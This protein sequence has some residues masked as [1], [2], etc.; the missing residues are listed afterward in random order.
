MQMPQIRLE[1]TFARVAM[2]TTKPIQEIQQPSADLSIEQP[3]ADLQ[4]ETTPGKLTIDQS[5]ARA[6]VDLKS[7]ARRKEEF[8]QQG[9]QDW[10][11]GM[12][13]VSQ[14]GDQLMRIEDGGNPLIDQAK[15][16]SENPMYDFNIGWIPSHGSVKINYTPANV[17]I[18]V[19]RNK[20]NI[21]VQVNK[22]I[23]S[24]Q[25]GKVNFELSQRNTL[26]INF[27][28]LKYVGINYEQ[29]I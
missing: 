13:R 28:N 6:D 18:D 16:N 2:T 1:S 8:A 15:V 5:Q 25:Q 21:Q 27:D 14:D 4:I 10:L 22:A 11:S 17:K 7:I 12:A 20:P 29:E 3:K 23:T 19:K 9:Y 26:N 24:Y